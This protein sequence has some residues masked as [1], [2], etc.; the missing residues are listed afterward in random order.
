MNETNN[1]MKASETD[2]VLD[3]IG[4]ATYSRMNETDPEEVAYHLR[5]A[6]Q[7]LEG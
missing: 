7:I 6:L 4:K 1:P 5:Q 2:D 3:H